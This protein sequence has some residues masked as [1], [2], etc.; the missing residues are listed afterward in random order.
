MNRCKT[1]KWWLRSYALNGFE[2]FYDD[3]HPHGAFCNHAKWVEGDNFG[4]NKENAYA[5][6]SMTYPSHEGLWFWTGPDFGCV[7]HEER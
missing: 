7:H 2:G 4:K 5:D 3:F 1:C 6:D